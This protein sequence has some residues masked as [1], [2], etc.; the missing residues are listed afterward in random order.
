MKYDKEEYMSALLTSARDSGQVFAHELTEP[1]FCGDLSDEQIRA[2]LDELRECRADV[3][4]GGKFVPGKHELRELLREI[5]ECPAEKESFAGRTKN[6][7]PIRL[8]FDELSQLDP[9]DPRMERD[10]VCEAA[11]GNDEA[12]GRLI[13]LCMYIPVTAAFGLIGKNALFSDLVQE[14][15]MELMAAAD[16][17]DYGSGWSFSGYAALRVGRYL[18][19]LTADQPETV[20][21]P[22]GL[23]EDIVKILRRK[24][25]MKKEGREPTAA[26]IAAAEGISEERVE[27]ALEALKAAGGENAASQQE[28]ETE[29]KKSEA[30]QQLSAQVAQLLA[31]LPEMEAQVLE[32]RY[33]IGGASPL[34]EKETAERLSISEEEVKKLEAAALSHLGS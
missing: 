9:P 25:Q 18:Y 4:P 11:E 10:L 21:L 30:E 8:Y 13:E 15:N 5:R 27:K 12:T 16:E 29:P 23:A 3:V 14:G 28:T 31:A 19:S 26:A 1:A 6:E 7:D 2:I 17:F 20:R 24:G 33:G 32:M 22:T 34:S